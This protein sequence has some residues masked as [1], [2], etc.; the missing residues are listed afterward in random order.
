MRGR[1]PAFPLP[2]GSPRRV[3]SVHPRAMSLGGPGLWCQPL[4][5]SPGLVRRRVTAA[6]EPLRADSHSLPKKCFSTIAED[7]AGSFNLGK[8]WAGGQRGRSRRSSRADPGAGSP[9]GELEWAAA[10]RGQAEPH[11]SRTESRSAPEGPGGP[12]ACLSLARSRRRLLTGVI[13]I[14]QG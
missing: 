1:V 6:A 2:G 8:G 11:S 14:A 12:S 3:A 10:R 4:A 9:A 7:L 13:S 5:S